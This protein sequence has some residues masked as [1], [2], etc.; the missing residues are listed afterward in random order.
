VIDRV[1]ADGGGGIKQYALAIRC[2]VLALTAGA[3]AVWFLETC[4]RGIME[5]NYR[6]S[7]GRIDGSGSITRHR[8]RSDLRPSSIAVGPDGSVWFGGSRGRLYR[9]TVGRLTPSGEVVEFSSPL[10]LPSSIEV[11]PEGRLWFPSSTGGRLIN[12]MDS[13]G[14][15][16]DIGQPICLDSGCTLEPTGLATGPDGSIWFSA[17]RAFNPGGGGGSAI[18]ESQRI[19]AEAGFIGRLS[20]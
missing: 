9:P 13:I 11:G 5:A 10:M 3:D 15:A 8:L 4:G 18:G 2:R 6:A 1:A 14:P 16:G 20:P 12:A 19:A 17:G 7:I